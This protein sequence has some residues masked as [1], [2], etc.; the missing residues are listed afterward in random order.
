M[1]LACYLENSVVSVNG[2][3]IHSALHVDKCLRTLV[4][5]ML[6]RS[7][8][9][10][11]HLQGREPPPQCKRWTAVL[12]EAISHPTQLQVSPETGPEGMW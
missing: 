12:S 2:S 4:I 10:S 1:L 5:K 7:L 8:T 9:K 3:N 6:L 11:P